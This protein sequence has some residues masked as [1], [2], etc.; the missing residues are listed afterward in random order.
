MPRLETWIIEDEPPAQ[1]RLEKLLRNLRP[2]AQVTF[3]TDTITGAR[4]ALAERPHPD[5][6]F[7]DIEL[8]DGLSFDIWCA[9]EARCPIV[10]T[11]A[12]DQY[13]IRAFEV[14]SVD[15]LLKPIEEERLAQALDKFDAFRQNTSAVPLD[16]RALSQLIAAREPAYRQRFVLQHRQ[17]WIAVRTDEFAHF[18]SA[19]GLTFGLTHARQRHLL[20]ETLDRLAEQLDPSVWHRISRSQIVHAGAIERAAPYFN[21]RLKLALKPAADGMDNVVSR[22]RVKGFLEWWG[23]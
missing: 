12:Y 4:A 1:R 23:R 2:N 16:L 6:I 17:E 20:P 9:A 22:Q 7:S 19:D 15:Y 10:F 8:A 13:A 3:S 5:L 18:Y 21:H 14:N 11:T